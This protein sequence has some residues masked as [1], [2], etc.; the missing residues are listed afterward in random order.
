MRAVIATEAGGPEV[1]TVTDL[2]DP[3]AGAGEVVLEVARTHA[4]TLV[5]TVYSEL[6]VNNRTGLSLVYGHGR[7]DDSRVVSV[8]ETLAGISVATAKGDGE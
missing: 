2:P 7:E 1:L 3:E 6:W 8:Y 4:D 5:V